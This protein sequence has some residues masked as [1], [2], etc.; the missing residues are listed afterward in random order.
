MEQA[1][2][3]TPM[4]AIP[5]SP[6]MHSTGLIFASL[7]TLSAGG[8]VTTLER[9]SFDAHE[10]L[11]A[12]DSSGARTWSAAIVGDA[13]ALPIVRAL[14]AGPPHGGRYNARSLR[15]LCSAGVAWSAHIK[16]RLLEHLPDVTLIDSCGASE[17]V[18][19]GTSTVRHGD[20][21][22]TASFDAAP[23][24][25]VLSPGGAELPQGEV[26]MLAG[27]TTASGYHHAPAQT[28]ATFMRLGGRQYGARRPGTHRA[29]WHGDAGIGRGVA[30]ISTGGGRCRKGETRDRELGRAWTIVSCSACL[31]SASDRWSPPWSC[32][33]P[34]VPLRPRTSRRPCEHRL[35]ATRSRVTCGS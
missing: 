5:A 7:P 14:D 27:P 31:M 17:G 4:R 3:G 24:L 32:A 2:R 26:G 28:A 15:V 11:A 18:A 30:T 8:T 13:F 9:R 29:R 22:A 10:L 23:G 35:R 16:E 21:V 25:K 34:A 33:I 19:Y 20:P 6:L 1:E 12:V